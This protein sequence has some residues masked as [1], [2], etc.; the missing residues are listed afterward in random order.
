MR[1]SSENRGDR[2]EECF[3]LFNSES[4][5]STVPLFC[6]SSLPSSGTPVRKKKKEDGGEHRIRRRVQVRKTGS[7]RRTERWTERQNTQILL[8]LRLTC[9]DLKLFPEL[10]NL[11]VG[12]ERLDGRHLDLRRPLG[13]GNRDRL[14]FQGSRNPKP[15][16]RLGR[17]RPRLG[18]GSLD[19][20]VSQFVRLGELQFFHLR[21]RPG[22]PDPGQS[23]GVGSLSLP[24]LA[25]HTKLTNLGWI[26]VARYRP[27]S[28]RHRRCGQRLSVPNA[29]PVNHRSRLRPECDR[30][31]NSSHKRQTSSSRVTR[32]RHHCQLPI[33]SRL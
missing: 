29:V 30:L 13:A 6:S 9:E 11:E 3:C 17:L 23:L 31:D 26:Q 14:G 5:R 25:V 1:L 7:E 4:S 28:F 12:L 27:S 18:A 22:N 2:G 20:L 10:D 32:R 15:R 16:F 24:N 33:I 21:L 8:D 19:R